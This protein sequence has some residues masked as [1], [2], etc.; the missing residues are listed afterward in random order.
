MIYVGQV[1]YDNKPD[2]MLM[3]IRLFH[4]HLTAM[5]IGQGFM[6]LANGD[7][8]ECQFRNGRA[9]GPGTYVSVKG[10][11]MKGK[12]APF[13]RHPLPLALCFKGH[14][15]RTKRRASS[16]WW[17]QKALIGMR[18]TTLRASAWPRRRCAFVMPLVLS[19]EY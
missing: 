7:V 6:F 3:T 8:H 15:T 2:G 10:I 12:Y 4:H 18:S 13:N 1:D 14:G 16:P 19:V 17:T 9:D 5:P 11:E